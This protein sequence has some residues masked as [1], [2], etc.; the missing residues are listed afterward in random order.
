MEPRMMSVVET[1]V[2]AGRIH[3]ALSLEFL[4]KLEIEAAL[5]GVAARLAAELGVHQD[6]LRPIRMCLSAIDRMLGQSMSV[7]VFADYV[8][9]NAS[10]HQLV[11]QLSPF[12]VLA[13]YLDSERVTPFKLPDMLPAV[14]GN[15]DLFRRILVLEQEQ[16]RSIVEA[17][18]Q[19]HGTRA[20]DLLRGHW[21]IAER[22]L[23]RDRAPPE[24]AKAPPPK[25]ERQA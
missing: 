21:R 5:E 22:Q 24:L 23:A 16:H 10:F 17:I 12:A 6:Q 14:Q 18:V 15:L 25:T 8:E 1:I 3:A 20:E 19:R 4:K 11:L 9:L 13:R 7:S 2:L